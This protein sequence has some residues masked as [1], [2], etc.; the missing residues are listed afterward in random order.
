MQIEPV[1]NIRHVHKSDISNTHL[2]PRDAQWKQDLP[3][4]AAAAHS[5]SSAALCDL[6]VLGVSWFPI[7]KR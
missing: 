2:L 7:Q 4:L 6:W 1:F 3:E 5:A